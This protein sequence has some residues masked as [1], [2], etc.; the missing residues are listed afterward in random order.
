MTFII[1][2]LKVINDLFLWIL[3]SNE[4]EKEDEEVRMVVKI[5]DFIG[6]EIS[7]LSTQIILALPI[8]IN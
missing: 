3:G 8:N 5:F 2:F 6:S 4:E 1:V 7:P